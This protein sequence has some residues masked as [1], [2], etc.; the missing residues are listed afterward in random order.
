MG[1]T[2]KLTTGFGRIFDLGFIIPVVGISLGVSWL[3]GE[4]RR[5]GIL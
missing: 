5:R 2:N 4:L 1:R 3:M